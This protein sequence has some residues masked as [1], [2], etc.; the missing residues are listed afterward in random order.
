MIRFIPIFLWISVLH[1][2]CNEN[3]EEVQLPILTISSDS[4]AIGSI[5]GSL[6]LEVMSEMLWTVVDT[7]KWCTA[8]GDKAIGKGKITIVIDEN[9]NEFPRETFLFIYAGAEEA[10]VK[11]YQAPFI[12]PS[13]LPLNLDPV[14][15]VKGNETFDT[16][17]KQPI[18]IAEIMNCG[19]VP[20]SNSH[21]VVLLN[22]TTSRISVTWSHISST[23]GEWEGVS[24]QPSAY[25]VSSKL[26]AVD[27]TCKSVPT[28]NA[29]LVKKYGDWDHQHANGFFFAPLEQNVYMRG[30]DKIMIDFYYDLDQT[31][32]PTLDEIGKA[33]GLGGSDLLNWDKGLFNFD[34]QINT[35]ENTHA[36]FN[37]AL[38]PSMGNKW[39]RIEIPTAALKCWNSGNK[40]ISYASMERHKLSNIS[41]SAETGNRLV[42]RNINGAGFNTN[43]PKLFKEIAF[44]IKRFELVRKELD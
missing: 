28:Y 8:D 1:V 33:Y 26:N 30:L 11:I 14:V 2:S 4:L 18:V 32:I 27:A 41:I 10:K 6:E 15:I 19:D 21:N 40:A 34:I 38:E 36:A 12:H 23:T 16:L 24:K 9:L 13:L 35:V 31:V 25:Q 44:K 37:L 17:T 20:N 43:T 22:A 5:G 29:I 3:T 7:S 39:L 42:Y